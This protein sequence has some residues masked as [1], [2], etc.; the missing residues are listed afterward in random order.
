[1]YT[2]EVV[3]LTVELVLVCEEGG[4]LLELFVLN[5]C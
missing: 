3:N 4:Q 2:I 5:E 1:M